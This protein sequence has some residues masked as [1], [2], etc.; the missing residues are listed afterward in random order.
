M[1][2]QIA[3]TAPFPGYCPEYFNL[4]F[5]ENGSNIVTVRSQGAHLTSQ[6]NLPPEELERIGRAMINRAY[7]LGLE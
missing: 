4:T 3:Y 5:C 7:E 2:K 1:S 6:I